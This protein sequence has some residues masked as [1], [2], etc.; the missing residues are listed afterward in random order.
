MPQVA[1]LHVKRISIHQRAQGRAF[2]GSADLLSFNSYSPA[3]SQRCIYMAIS[4]VLLFFNTLIDLSQENLDRS[5]CCRQ[6]GLEL[7]CLVTDDP[8]KQLCK[9]RPVDLYTLFQCPALVVFKV[10]CRCLFW[11]NDVSKWPAP[12]S[13][14]SVTPLGESCNDKHPGGSMPHPFF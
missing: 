7:V 10:I 9:I 2:W 13:S 1:R 14:S 12:I 6:I 5:V 3:L 11:P 8:I 4:L